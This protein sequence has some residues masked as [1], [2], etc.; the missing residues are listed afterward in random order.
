MPSPRTDSITSSAA[1]RGSNGGSGGPASPASGGGDGPAAAAAAAAAAQA[2]ALR[3][4]AGLRQS[5]LLEALSG[6]VLAAPLPPPVPPGGRLQLTRYT[7]HLLLIQYNAARLLTQLRASLGPWLEG[8]AVRYH[9]VQP[10]AIRLHRTALEQVA[11][12]RPEPL[13][14]AAESGQAREPD[15]DGATAAPQ[16]PVGVAAAGPD[17]ACSAGPGPSGAQPTNRQG[18]TGAAAASAGPAGAAMPGTAGPHGATP[19][20]A[21]TSPASPRS[22]HA[23]SSSRM[24]SVSAVAAA[25]LAVCCALEFG[26]AIATRALSASAHLD[27]ILATIAYATAGAVAWAVTAGMRAA[28]G[29]VQLVGHLGTGR[30]AARSPSVEPPAAANERLLLW[31]LLQPRALRLHGGPAIQL[32]EVL[33][34]LVNCAAG[35]GLDLVLPDYASAVATL[36]GAA[37]ALGRRAE[38]LGAR[39]GGKPNAHLLEAFMWLQTTVMDRLVHDLPRQEQSA[40][41]SGL[42]TLQGWLLRCLVSPAVLPGCRAQELTFALLLQHGDSSMRQWWQQE[43]ERR[44]QASAD[45]GGAGEP[46]EGEGPPLRPWPAQ[47]ALGVLPIADAGWAALAELGAGADAAE[48]AALA[49]SRRRLAEVVDWCGVAAIQLI[50]AMLSEAARAV[51]VESR[52]GTAGTGS[53]GESGGTTEQE[54]A[55]VSFARYLTRLLCCFACR[56]SPAALEAAAPQRA[57]AAADHFLERVASTSP[58]GQDLPDVSFSVMFDMAN[59]LLAL[60]SDER[61]RRLVPGWF[62]PRPATQ[63]GADACVT[64]W[65]VG[66][67]SQGT[68]AGDADVLSHGALPCYPVAMADL[69]S[70]GPFMNACWPDDLDRLGPLVMAAARRSAMERG[71]FGP[72]DR[73]RQ[74]AAAFGDRGGGGGDGSSWPPAALRVCGNPRCDALGAGAECA[75]PLKQCAGCRGVRYCCV[76]CQQAHWRGGHKAEIANGPPETSAAEFRAI[77]GAQLVGRAVQLV[78]DVLAYAS[79][80]QGRPSPDIKAT[81]SAIA[82]DPSER[83]SALLARLGYDGP[84]W[85]CWICLHFAAGILSA[86]SSVV[87]ATR[88]DGDWVAVA[89]QLSEPRT[90]AALAGAARFVR[91]RLWPQ[92]EAAG[93]EAEPKASTTTPVTK[94]PGA[95]MLCQTLSASERL[96]LMSP[97]QQGCFLL[98]HL[99]QTTFTLLGCCKVPTGGEGRQS[100][101]SDNHAAASRR[102]AQRIDTALRCSGLLEALLAAFLA[103]PLPPPVSPEATNLSLYVERLLLMQF[104]FVQTPTSVNLGLGPWLSAKA[105][106]HHLTQPQALRLRRTALEQMAMWRP[107]PPAAAAAAGQEAGRAAASTAGPGGCSSGLGL[108]SPGA[109]G[110][111]PSFAAPA[112]AAGRLWPLLQ[113]RAL[114][115]SLGPKLQITETLKLMVIC[116]GGGSLSGGVGSGVLAELLGGQDYAGLCLVLPDF[117][118]AVETLAGAAEALARRAEALAALGVPK[119]EPKPWISEAVTWLHATVAVRLQF[120]DDARAAM[121]TCL[122]SLLRLQGWLLRAIANRVVLAGCDWTALEM[123]LTTTRLYLD[124]SFRTDVVASGRGVWA[125]LCPAQRAA[126][127]EALHLS[128]WAPA[129]D[130]ALR[131]AAERGHLSH[132]DPEALRDGVA[133][134]KFSL[135][136]RL[137]LPATVAP[138]V[139]QWWQ[140]E[141]EQRQQVSSG[142]AEESGEG[143][144]GGEGPPLRP[145]PAQEALG[146]L[147][148]LAKLARRE[149][150]RMGGAAGEAGGSS[151]ASGPPQLL[152]GPKSPAFSIA[153]SLLAAQPVAD[154]GWAALAELGAGADAAEAAALAESRRRL[155]EVVDWCGVAAIQLATALAEEVAVAL[156]APRTPSGVAVGGGWTPPPIEQTLEHA[157]RL[158]EVLC[159]Y[160]CRC[161]PAALAAAAP[162]RALAA[163]DAVADATR[164]GKGAGANAAWERISAG[165]NLQITNAIFVLSSDQR[166]RHL[167]PGWYWPGPP[168]PDVDRCVSTWSVGVLSEEGGGRAVTAGAVPPRPIVRTQSHAG[169]ALA[170]ARWPDDLDRLGPL[171][172]AAA[173]RSAME[174]GLFGPGGRQRQWA[175]AFGDR[176]GGGG[177]G[178]SWP[179]VALRVCGNPRC[180][181]LGAG[182]ECALPLKQCAGCRGVRYCCVGCQQAHWRG[183]HKAECGRAGAGAGAEEAG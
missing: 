129:L 94:A 2:L 80:T 72:G 109:A 151:A 165:L 150:A 43:R 91:E 26:L 11:M 6:A 49:E 46:G 67:L 98:G 65:N 99:Q 57:L 20:N 15:V 177:G 76:G 88:R 147:V 34:V 149:A 96:G 68:W 50:T 100:G 21:A 142:G 161:S 36:A 140:Q 90:F 125:S 1:A 167:V 83:I 143:E 71:L 95:L 42:M 9:L 29:R 48:A 133:A 19:A 44:R 180:D 47:E 16:G 119:G 35:A 155:G 176:G 58:A 127:Q 10:R 136:V 107:K 171:V 124:Y 92:A 132:Q 112:V 152:L 77:L 41:L 45:G 115:L 74:W 64:A 159:S 174:R 60:A 54:E 170:N 182:A 163:L 37:E 121:S 73:Q 30:P 130:R 154:A 13:V 61:L 75:L 63:P 39:K 53:H 175:A 162:Q 179:P 144:G 31:P 173:R 123:Q 23:R 62:W 24:P 146:V 55:A 86:V 183:G 131:W 85:A 158:G 141:R 7:W 126:A 12:W 145:W 8:A 4:E 104:G 164:T 181:A 78:E 32:S 79:T 110:P 122:P 178:G 70:G 89:E 106:R 135:P 117:P 40:N 156:K 153:T 87:A 114:R 28:E 25:V 97:A 18:R 14:T 111:G 3:L 113:P 22:T 116:A 56:C 33:R 17:N 108:R 120:T 69:P 52:C 81:D 59:T 101:A 84:S 148:T 138:S 93:V 103:A 128:G 27:A 166:L 139:R 102:L 82:D 51:D 169:A 134:E 137:L 168:A 5:G 105:V 38:A 172:M 157:A 160:A 66:V 118:S